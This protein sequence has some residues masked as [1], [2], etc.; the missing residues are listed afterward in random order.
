M[1]LHNCELIYDLFF[2]HFR[3]KG[4]ALHRPPSKLMI[5]VFDTQAGFESYLGQKVP[6]G[7]VGF[8]HLG[9]NRLVIY[10][11]A[12]N[13][14]Y[15][16]AKRYLKDQGRG[17]GSDMDRTRYVETVDRLARE[18][19][20]DANIAVI[21]HETAHQLSFNCGLMNRDGDV[22]LWAAE[23]LATY[24]EA[25][26]NLAWQGIGEANPERLR[27]LAMARAYHAP[28]IPLRD[29]VG[30]DAWLR[31]ATDFN[32]VLLGYAQSWA[33]FRMLMEE[34]PQ[35]MRNYL[36]TIYNR[37]GIVHRL[38]DFGEAFGSDLARLDLRHQQYIDEVID[39]EYHPPKR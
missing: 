15:V 7:M 17:I 32:Q 10:D 35:A 28:L 30:S 27:M 20:T 19:R 4:F 13:R 21:M 3:K 18:W 6:D 23:G 31:D 8:Y 26:D 14:T 34:R 5:A 38:T 11:L 25:T 12:Q 36:A 2:D 37:R 39:R 22:P 29:L 9:T 24:C 16:A 1:R 33:L